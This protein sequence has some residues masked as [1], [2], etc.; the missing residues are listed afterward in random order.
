MLLHCKIV[1]HKNIAYQEVNWLFRLNRIIPCSASYESQRRPRNSSVESSQQ[2]QNRI[3][4]SCCF[5]NLSNAT[6]CTN[7]GYFMTGAHSTPISL[8]QYRGLVK[9]ATNNSTTILTQSQWLEIENNVRKRLEAYCPIC[10][11]GFNKGFEVLLSCSHMYHR[12]VSFLLL[13]N[14]L[15]RVFYR[16]RRSRKLRKDAVQSAGQADTTKKSRA[17]VPKHLK[18]FVAFGSNRIGEDIGLLSKRSLVS[19]SHFYFLYSC[20]KVHYHL[21]KRLYSQVEFLL[22]CLI[23]IY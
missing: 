9:P 4:G 7:C 17:L 20:R 2:Q 10:M 19:S 12:S 14:F 8:A 5:S 15:D 18:L 6:V 13:F 16:S 21:L 23:D 22:N 1:L 11:E 3:C